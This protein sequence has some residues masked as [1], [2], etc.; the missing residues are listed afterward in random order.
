MNENNSNQA[1]GIDIIGMLQLV[2]RR[3]FTIALVFLT[4]IGLTAFFTFTATPVYEA[5]S[6]LLISKD[7]AQVSLE[8]MFGMDPSQGSSF[9]TR[10]SMIKSKKLAKA[11]F[12]SLKAEGQLPPDI[13]TVDNLHSAIDAEPQ[14]NTRIVEVSVRSIDP[15]A[16]ALA[17]NLVAREF[18]DWYNRESKKSISFYTR[19][20]EI[21]EKQLAETNGK[22]SDFVNKYGLVTPEMWAT[23]RDELSQLRSE[24]KDTKAQLR[25]RRSVLEQLKEAQENGGNVTDLVFLKKDPLFAALE[26]QLIEIE[27]EYSVASQIYGPEHPKMMTLKARMVRQREDL[28]SVAEN[29]VKDLEYEA[30]LT[31]TELSEL[32]QEYAESEAKAL[33]MLTLL[34]TYTKL[35]RNLESSQSLYDIILQKMRESGISN[36]AEVEPTQVIDTALVPVNPVFPKVKLNMA[37]G[38]ILG[39]LFAL[40]I[41]YG[42]DF[43]DDSVKT[44]DEAIAALTDPDSAESIPM[45]GAIGQIAEHSAGASAAKMCAD[46]PKSVTAEAYR[47]LRTGIVFSF[48]ERGPRSILITG[49]DSGAGKTTNAS[50]LGI[51]LAQNN[52]KTVLIDADMRKPMIHQIWDTENEQGLS[53]YLIG[54]SELDDVLKGSEVENLDLIPSGPTPPL[55]SELLNC[56]KFTEL[57]AKLKESYDYVLIDSPPTHVADPMII[58]SHVD[59]TAVVVRAGKSSR[60]GLR[61]LSTQMKQSKANFLGVI[62][63]D[64]DS[65]LQYGSYYSRYGY[66]YYG[67]GYGHK[68]KDNSSQATRAASF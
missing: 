64:A 57:I 41:A 68:K 1:N 13:N 25:N 67:Y 20:L 23:Y 38:V 28:A 8:D 16:S 52:F 35:E 3:I 19:Q 11:V 36:S 34:Q 18:I 56:D 30:E 31:K 62:L 29:L 50:N 24:V 60:R 5:N 14:R 43:F 22:I 40:G 17:T 53:S 33:E 65:K 63:N 59:G 27:K 54:T 42:L 49:S 51:V 7:S 2:R 4:V 61:F 6:T 12:E 39:L 9:N 15:E 37:L 21:L 58:A 45:L 32:E 48:T 44:A 55:P 46:S 47:T 66:S 26:K 10:V